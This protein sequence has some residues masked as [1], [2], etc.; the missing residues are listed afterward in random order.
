[1]PQIPAK[2]VVKGVPLAEP[3]VVE[4]HADILMVGGG[5]GCCGAAFECAAGSTPSTRISP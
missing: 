4:Q 1:M 5:M 3:H 2:D